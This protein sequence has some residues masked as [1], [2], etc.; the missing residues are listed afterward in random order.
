ME[1]VMLE[2]CYGFLHISLGLVVLA[3]WA[4]HQGFF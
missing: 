4:S 1:A 3:T 2:L